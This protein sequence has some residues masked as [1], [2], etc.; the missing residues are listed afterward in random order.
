MNVVANKET[1][2]TFFERFSAADVDGALA[3]LDDGVVWRTMGREGGLPL[4]GT[5]DKKGIGNLIGSVAEGMPAGLKLEPRGW[6]IQDNR[7]ALEMESFGELWDGTS[8]NNMHHFMITVDRGRICCV[9]EY[10]DTLH[11]KNVFLDKP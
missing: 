8:Y 7:V 10:M 9:R 3:L 1:V 4:S 6:T 5:M 11:V 2:R